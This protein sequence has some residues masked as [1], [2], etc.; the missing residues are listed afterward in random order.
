MV[1][2]IAFGVCTYKGIFDAGAVLE[3]TI[4]F[5]FSFYIF[6]FCIDLWPAIHTRAGDG[7]KTNSLG[8]GQYTPPS[9]VA[10]SHAA[11]TEMEEGRLE[12]GAVSDKG[13]S[14]IPPTGTYRGSDMA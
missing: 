4:A 9:A 3:W 7:F 14:T 13:N 6:S 12:N 11:A 5:I 2:A 10:G 1:L 8:N